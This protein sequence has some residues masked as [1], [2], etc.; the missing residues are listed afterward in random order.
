M[1]ATVPMQ[2]MPDFIGCLE[3]R[4]NPF[5]IL[6]T[7]AW[8]T[9]YLDVLKDAEISFCGCPGRCYILAHQPGPKRAHPGPNVRVAE[10]RKAFG[11]GALRVRTFTA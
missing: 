11:S 5:H 9:T 4:R 7:K 10:S 3:S 8:L 1:I 6:S 2:V